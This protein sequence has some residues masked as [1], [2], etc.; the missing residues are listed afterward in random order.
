MENDARILGIRTR[1]FG[2][3]RLGQDFVQSRLPEVLGQVSM[4]Q[5]YGQVRKVRLNHVGEGQTSWI[6]RIGR[7]NYEEMRSRPRDFVDQ[8]IE[9]I[10]RFN[11]V[12]AVFF[13][14]MHELTASFEVGDE[15]QNFFLWSFFRGAVRND[16]SEFGFWGGFHSAFY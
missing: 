5:A 12:G 8:L 11:H 15:Q 2:P 6:G 13:D 10:D 1:R 3:D 7:I 9:V 14:F 16:G 4:N